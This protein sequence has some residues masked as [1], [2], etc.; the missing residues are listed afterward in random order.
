MK[1]RL[2]LADDEPLEREALEKLLRPVLAP[3]DEMLVAASGT[4]AVQC[5][6]VG[7]IDIAILD[8]RMPGKSGLEVAAILRERY[9]AVHL[10]FISAYDY[11]AY[12]REAITLRAEDYLIKPVED[13]VIL[14]VAQRLIR[15]ARNRVSPEQRLVE[16]ERFLEFELLDDLAQGEPDVDLLRNALTLL[17]VEVAQGF[18]VVIRPDLESYS[19][20]LET[21]SQRRTVILRLLRRIKSALQTPGE[22]IMIRAWPREGFLIC[23]SH[24]R[25]PVTMSDSSELRAIITSAAAGVPLSVPNVHSAA[26]SSLTEL[27][28]LIRGL[29]RAVVAGDV[30]QTAESHQQR[31]IYSR[32]QVLVA[33]LNNDGTAAA[34][35]AR[36]LLVLLEHP[37]EEV[38]PILHY[39]LHA[40]E[41]RRGAP[42]A[43]RDFVVPPT[44]QEVT[45]WFLEHI[46]Q[47]AVSEEGES[48]ALKREIY[49]WFERHFSRNV[50]LEDLAAFLRFSPSHCSRTVT[51]QMGSSFSQYLRAVRLRHARKLLEET[52]ISIAAIAEKTGFRDSNY[53]SRVFT[54]HEGISPRQF[55]EQR[56]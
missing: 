45:P 48:T 6:E 35:R 8:I 31:V 33:L 44:A 25:K 15:S 13:E 9:P 24:S 56:A 54:H 21:D 49:H 7:P 41:A 23:F 11:F 26:F 27:A 51:L 42:L 30:L 4:E 2:L 29:R 55:R 5:A 3:E 28:Q 16:A 32:Q 10:V 20:A 12:A 1:L 37:R 47:L 14:R 50:G 43:P 38:L 19:F 52:E 53:F 36:E 40:I 39:L 18:V 34:A 22:R 46:A 17:E